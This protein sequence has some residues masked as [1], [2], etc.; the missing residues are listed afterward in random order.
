MRDSR[1][2]REGRL[3]NLALAPD[4]IARTLD[5]PPELRLARRTFLAGALATLALPWLPGGAGAAPAL[6]EA[7][8]QALEQSPYV[9]VSPLRRDGSESTCH[10]EV[11]FAWLDGAAVLITARTGWKCRALARGLDRARLWV[12]D[13]GRWRGLLGHNEA[14]RAAPSF[15]ARVEESKDPA[16]LDRLLQAYARKYPE[17]IPRW[18]DRMRA[19]FVSGERALLRYV[20]AAGPG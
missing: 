6:P 3:G 10:A 18:R 15:V 7:T 13:H 9:Y 17:E 8:Q 20:P 5:G 12:G 2:R 16:L 11:W 4:G 1:L 14:F 19:G